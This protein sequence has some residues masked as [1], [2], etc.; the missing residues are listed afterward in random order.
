MQRRAIFALEQVKKVPLVLLLAWL[1]PLRASAEQPQLQMTWGL[2]NTKF[3][4]LRATG[5]G[6]SVKEYRRNT[7]YVAAEQKLDNR[8]DGVFVAYQ[9]ATGRGIILKEVQEWVKQNDPY[10]LAMI[11]DLAPTFYFD[12]LGTSGK[13]YVLE[14][15]SIE[16]VAWSPVWGG[17]FADREAWYDVEIERTRGVKVF[18]VERKL[19][20][21]SSGR[22]VLR[23]WPAIGTGGFAPGGKFTIDITFTFLVDGQARKTSTG[24]FSIEL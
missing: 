3:Y 2:E 20:F 21:T 22:S 11:R 7:A 9:N 18:P 8:Q 15:I 4:E 10:H 24:R 1:I 12:F 23:L 16:T 5:A 6:S 19:R 14:T 13:E 17:G